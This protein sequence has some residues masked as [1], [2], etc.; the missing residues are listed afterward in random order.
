MN[1][2]LELQFKIADYF[3]FIFMKYCRYLLDKIWCYIS[4]DT[5]YEQDD[6]KYRLSNDLEK[7]TFIFLTYSSECDTLVVTYADFSN[8]FVYQSHLRESLDEHFC[9]LIT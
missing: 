9:L 1:E 7:Q 5:V 3:S 2:I 8:D 4:Y 6:L